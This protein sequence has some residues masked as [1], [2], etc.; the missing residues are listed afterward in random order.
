MVGNVSVSKPQAR[1]AVT[2]GLSLLL[3]PMVCIR[4]QAASTP[5]DGEGSLDLLLVLAHF[6]RLFWDGTAWQQR[7]AGVCQCIC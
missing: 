7:K 2:M 6:V 5:N 3:C 4:G 1:N